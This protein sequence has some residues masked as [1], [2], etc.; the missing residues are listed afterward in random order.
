MYI[1]GYERGM[2][3]SEKSNVPCAER[4]ICD[5]IRYSKYLPEAEVAEAVKMYIE[6]PDFGENSRIWGSLGASGKCC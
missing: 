4:A 3:F 2:G 1:P 6:D 5:Y